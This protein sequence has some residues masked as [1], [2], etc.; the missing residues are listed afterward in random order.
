[1]SFS[2]SFC[3]FGSNIKLD[4]FLFKVERFVRSNDGKQMQHIAIN[5]NCSINY[6]MANVA[7]IC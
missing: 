7:L 1:M 3:F 4:F 5:P 6:M 2:I